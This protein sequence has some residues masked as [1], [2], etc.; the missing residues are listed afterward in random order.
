MQNRVD[1]TSNDDRA[2]TRVRIVVA[3]SPPSHQARCERA[4]IFTSGLDPLV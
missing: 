3:L 1:E 4:V 2:R